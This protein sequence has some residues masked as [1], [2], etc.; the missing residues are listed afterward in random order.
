MASFIQTGSYVNQE[1]YLQLEMIEPNIFKTLASIFKR[2][3]E[4]Y[5][6]LKDFFDNISNECLLAAFIMNPSYIGLS[7]ETDKDKNST[8]L[9]NIKF[10]LALLDENC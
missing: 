5:N 4:K 6:K 1:H 9:R 10:L 3:K 8:I 2:K 7:N